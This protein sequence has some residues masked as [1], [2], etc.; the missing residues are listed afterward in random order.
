MV[1]AVS[2]IT[3]T[4]FAG[5]RF[6]ERPFDEVLRTGEPNFPFCLCWANVNWTG[7]WYGAP[8][9]TIV[10]QTY[11]GEADYAAHFECL[12][13][14]F[15]D[16]RYIRV[17]DRPLLL[18]WDP[19]DIPDRAFLL[20]YWRRRAIT[21][22]FKGIH[23]VGVRCIVRPEHRHWGFDGWVTARPPVFPDNFRSDVERNVPWVLEHKAVL[24]DLV[25]QIDN[26]DIDYP[27]T[28]PGWDNTPP[29]PGHGGLFFMGQ[30][31][32]CLG[33]L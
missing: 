4:G 19:Q 9:H 14:A 12:A 23:L 27:C 6:L 20:A 3:T 31:R 21:A 25:N 29:V 1:L 26:G 11:P 33:G 22:G 28:G 15:S 2:V 5:K 10:P 18:I 24:H 30:P 13:K 17:H 16:I 7:S 8:K 32:S